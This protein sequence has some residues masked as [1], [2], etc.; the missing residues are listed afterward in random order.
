MRPP[1]MD[2]RQRATFVMVVQEGTLS[3]AAR[4]LSY[5]QA[6]VTL[7]IQQLERE[8]GARLF[9]RIGKSVRITPAGRRV[10]TRARQ[11]LEAAEEMRREAVA[12]EAGHAGLVA[13]GCIEPTASVRL[14]R[15]LARLWTAY[16]AIEVRVEV[17][18][19]TSTSERVAAGDLDLGIASRPPAE[20]ALT[21][22]PLFDERLV[23][24]VSAARAR[25]MRAP[26]RA[27]DLSDAGVVLTE[28]GCAYRRAVEDAFTARGARLH[29]TLEMGSVAAL[30]GCV[31]EGLGAA[32][33]PAA[34]LR[35]QDKGLAVREIADLP[36]SIAVGLVARAQIS[37]P[38]G[39]VQV[40]R[41]HLRARLTKGPPARPV[42]RG[43]TA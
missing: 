33:V 16:P 34:A 40:V 27:R 25:K 7:H 42:R 3:A 14:P 8:L 19:T 1:V 10:H 15:V 5:S 39:A 35:H 26:L 6:A 24:V 32:I 38:S 18:G 28:H 37:G 13:L 30:L 36:M 22:E 2:L 20:F 43:P 41:E 21:Y 17:G 31:R 9:D 11:I 12:I 4:A 23:V 29:V